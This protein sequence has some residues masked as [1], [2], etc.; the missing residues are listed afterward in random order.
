MFTDDTAMARSVAQSII[1]TREVEVVD[2]AKRQV[3]LVKIFI[4]LMLFDLK[5][6]HLN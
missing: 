3:L 6:D 1:D 5:S 2:M 4:L